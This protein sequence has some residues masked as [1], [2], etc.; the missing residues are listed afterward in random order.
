MKLKKS[1]IK[2]I[3]DM[4]DHFFKLYMITLFMGVLS[5][6]TFISVFGSI[7]LFPN[8]LGIILSVIFIAFSYVIFVCLISVLFNKK[9]EEKKNAGQNKKANKNR[10]K[11]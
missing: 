7:V 10:T 1:T 3:E 8:Y 6:M 9:E 4:L 5:F 11:T 2:S